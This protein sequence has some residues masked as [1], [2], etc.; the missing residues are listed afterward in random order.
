MSNLIS[1]P[2][3]QHKGRL[4]ELVTWAI[5]EYRFNLDALLDFLINRL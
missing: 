5:S 1:I 2:S 3:N 4:I